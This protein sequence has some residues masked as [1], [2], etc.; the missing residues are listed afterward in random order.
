M[1]QLVPQLKVLH[2]P[3]G[4]QSIQKALFAASHPVLESVK[5]RIDLHVLSAEA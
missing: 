5:D 3:K 4:Q 2:L 1:I